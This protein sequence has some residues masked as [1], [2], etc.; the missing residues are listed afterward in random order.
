M[1]M[2]ESFNSEGAVRRYLLGRV[3]DE[4][5]LEGLEELLF[6]DE[7][8]CTRV[9]LAE[10]ELVN[11]YVLGFLDEEDAADFVATLDSNPERR[12]KLELTRALRE[13]ALASRAGAAAEIHEAKATEASDL[14]GAQSLKAADVKTQTGVRTE[15][16]GPSFLSSLGALL[17]RPAYAGAFAL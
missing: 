9:A 5:T 17:R 4:A 15:E 8:F 3:S 6:T 1:T 10:D 12:F 7:E 16:V 14:K 11:D 2:G 13:K